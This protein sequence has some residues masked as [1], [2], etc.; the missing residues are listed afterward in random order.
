MH[1][2][3]LW[4]LVFAL[5]FG[6]WFAHLKAGWQDWLG[7]AAVVAGIPW[8]CAAATKCVL[9]IPFVVHPQMKKVPASSRNARDRATSVSVR[10][11][12]PRA[13][14]AVVTGVPASA[15]LPQ[16]GSAPRGA[17][18]TEPGRSRRTSRTSGTRPSLVTSG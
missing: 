12:D 18:P 3:S 7:A 15:S 14:A 9:M 5:L 2:R 8:S 10:T 11:A 4:A 17:R 13:P 6:V 1:T 16:P